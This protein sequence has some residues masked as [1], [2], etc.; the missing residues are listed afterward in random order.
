[1]VNENLKKIC[2]DAR[3]GRD[4]VNRLPE[5][6]LCKEVSLAICYKSIGIGL[7][8][9]LC[10]GTFQGSAHYW[11]RLDDVIYD[12][13]ADQFD[14]SI[15]KIYIVR[16]SKDR[17]YKEESFVIFNKTVLEIISHMN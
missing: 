10:Q 4:Q 1:M 12:A 3:N 14:R 8:P 6:Y 2:L 17:R 13:T 16:E 5:Q 15:D 9:C 11:V 7:T